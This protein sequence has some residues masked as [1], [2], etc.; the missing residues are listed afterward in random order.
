[1]VFGKL[2]QIN[3]K[4]KKIGYFYSNLFLYK[5]AKLTN[6]PKNIYKKIFF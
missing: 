6:F 5:K 2:K 1:M 3:R 4:K